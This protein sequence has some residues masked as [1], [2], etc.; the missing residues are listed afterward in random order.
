MHKDVARCAHR[1]SVR[2]HRGSPESSTCAPTSGH[3]L[4]GELCGA[5]CD[6]LSDTMRGASHATAMER[7]AAAVRS[8][9]RDGWGRSGPVGTSDLISRGKAGSDQ[10]A[11]AD[12]AVLRS[13]VAATRLRN[14]RWFTPF[15]ALVNDQAKLLVVLIY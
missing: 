15:Y 14:V 5:S 7:G 10:N 2:G 11:S 6:Q 13:R 1:M 9:H 3:L 12:L 8:G 4:R